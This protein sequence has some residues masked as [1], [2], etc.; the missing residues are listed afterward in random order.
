MKKYPSQLADQFNVRLPA[1]WRDAL[2]E[3]AWRNR[4]SMNQEI[5]AALEPVVAKEQERANASP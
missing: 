3:A 4:R 2:K 5:L 1:S